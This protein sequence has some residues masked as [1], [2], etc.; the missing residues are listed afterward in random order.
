MPDLLHFFKE[1]APLFTQHL[2]MSSGRNYESYTA[3]IVLLRVSVY[4]GR[5]A[6]PPSSFCEPGTPPQPAF[7]PCIHALWTHSLAEAHALA[8]PLWP[9]SP[10]YK[11]SVL[12]S[13][14]PWMAGRLAAPGPTACRER[15]AATQA[16]TPL[17]GRCCVSLACISAS[18]GPSSRTVTVPIRHSHA[19]QVSAELSCPSE[20]PPSEAGAGNTVVAFDF[21]VRF[22]LVING[23]P[24]PLQPLS[25]PSILFPGV[26]APRGCAYFHVCPVILGPR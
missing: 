20:G 10:P 7:L 19:H 26:P 12:P 2:P 3:E 24:L 13:T 8:A 18:R 21:E 6:E 23:G 9:R 25:H 1:R 11:L 15:K 16:S 5:A 14:Y 17:A 22:L 4:P